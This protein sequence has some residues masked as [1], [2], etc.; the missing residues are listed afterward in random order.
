MNRKSKIGRFIEHKEKQKREE[1]ELT[2]PELGRGAWATVSV[3]R[4]RGAQ[5]AVKRIHNQLVSRHNIQLFRRE[6]NMA[7]K[8]RHPNFVQFL[9]ATV[10]GDM[11]IIME[12][13]T[14][15]LRRQLQSEEYF[16]PKFVKSISMDVARAPPNKA[17]LHCAS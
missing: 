12:Y 11:M 13:M 1:I 5:V 14:P 17:R 7:A 2:G 10:E 15:S 8:L 4:F 6:M 16:Q 9:G 3:A